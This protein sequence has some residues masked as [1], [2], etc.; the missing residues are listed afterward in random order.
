[1]NAKLIIEYIDGTRTERNFDNYLKALEEQ[2]KTLK[3]KKQIK[4]CEV[5]INEK[6]DYK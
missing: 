6:N 2:R 4:I 1:M 5:K 3:S